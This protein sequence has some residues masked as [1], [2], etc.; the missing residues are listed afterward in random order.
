MTAMLQNWLSDLD[1]E[2]LLYLTG[3]EVIKK[4]K[5][6]ILPKKM[7]LVSFFS[8]RFLANLWPFSRLALVNVLV[9]RPFPYIKTNLSE[10]NSD[11][12]SV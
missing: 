1:I 5:K 9:A 4:G 2:N 12:F 8:N 6:M 3:F 10:F 7:P 11:R